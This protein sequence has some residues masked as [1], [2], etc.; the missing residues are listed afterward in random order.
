[1]H[2]HIHTVLN[3]RNCESLMV[4]RYHQISA[5]HS[6][7]SLYIKPKGAV[8]NWLLAHLRMRFNVLLCQRYVYFERSCFLMFALV[9]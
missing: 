8:N 9:V 4:K 1:M 2:V 3:I 5:V 6:E 7:S